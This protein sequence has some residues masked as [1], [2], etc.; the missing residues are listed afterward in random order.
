MKMEYMA[1]AKFTTSEEISIYRE[2]WN[3]K[4]IRKE[5]YLRL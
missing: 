1:K 3:W 2:D 4:Q 5:I